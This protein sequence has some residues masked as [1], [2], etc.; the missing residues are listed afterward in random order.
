MYVTHIVLFEGYK[1]IVGIKVVP[2]GNRNLA[3]VLK[4]KIKGKY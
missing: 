2:I 3:A 4:L 1:I